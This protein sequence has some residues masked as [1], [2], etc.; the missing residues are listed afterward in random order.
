MKYAIAILGTCLLAVGLATA[1]FGGRDG[2]G[3]GQVEALVRS[4]ARIDAAVEGATPRPQRLARAPRGRGERAREEQA[5]S[6]ASEALAGSGYTIPDD[7]TIDGVAVG[8]RELLEDGL[9]AERLA[10]ADRA[11]IDL[12]GSLADYGFDD[13]EGWDDE[14]WDGGF[15]IDPLSSFGGLD[16]G[17]VRAGSSDLPLPEG[18]VLA[19]WDDLMVPDYEPPSPLDPDDGYTKEDLFP[20]EVLAFDG[21][22]VAVEGFMLPTDFKGSRVT[23][24]V[25][26]PYPPGCCFGGMPGMDEWID[27]EVDDPNGVEYF[28]YRTVRVIGTFEVGELLDDYGY[29]RSIFRQRA[30][31]VERLW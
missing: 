23:A 7:G 28:A 24:F 1:F 17:P 11:T 31:T 9:S 12:G 21:R 16:H 8:A 19:T 4:A 20:A 25:L 18:V 26:S 2:A 6:K 10:Q 15:Q 13:G 22:R 3:D 5:A 27:V 30:Q 29:V 14:G